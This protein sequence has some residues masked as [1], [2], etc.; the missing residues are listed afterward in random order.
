MAHN[1]H[2]D[3]PDEEFENNFGKLFSIVDDLFQDSPASWRKWTDDLK[4]LQTRGG[5]PQEEE[6]DLHMLAAKFEKWQ[7]EIRNVI[8]MM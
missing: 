3:M 7:Q 8:K 4:K 1:H 6:E 2:F 5:G